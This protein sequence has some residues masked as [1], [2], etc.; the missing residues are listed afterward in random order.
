MPFKSSL[1][2]ALLL[3]ILNA[4]SLLAQT[5]ELNLDQGRVLARQA[6]LN[7]QFNVA[8]SL[9][10]ALLQA[11]P[12]D[13]AAL[14]ILAASHPQN[15]DAR[16]GRR[17]GA[18]AFRLS[19]TPDE[20]YEAARLT[21]LAA[22]NEE[23]YTL[24]QYW[25]RRAAANAPNEQALNQTRNDY[26]GLRRLNP[27]SFNINGTISP[28]NNLNGGS[29]DECLVIEGVNDSDGTPLCG[30][31]SGDAQALSGWAATANVTLNYVISR[32]ANQR[33]SLTARG[34]AR[35]VWLSDEAQD[36]SPRSRNSDFATQVLELGVRHQ[37][38]AGEGAITAEGLYGWSWFGGELSAQYARGR[39]SY[40]RNIT[41]QTELSMTAQLDAIDVQSAVAPRTNYA[42]SLSASFAHTLDGGNR[43][44]GSVGISGQSSEQPNERF[45]TARLQLGY[46]WGEQIGPAQLSVGAG[47]VWSDYRDYTVA[48]IAV[49]DG[50]QDTRAFATVSAAFPDVEYAGF[51]PVVSTSYQ[52]TTSNVSRFER[53]EFNLSLSIRSSF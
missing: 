49:P 34:Y 22:A 2:A 21:A 45:E 16:D 46:A 3:I 17:A 8:I 39:L 37:R 15:G 33:T 50:R 30:L 14:V 4:S 35:Q 40:S 41:Q 5:L 19:T 18:Q 42:R 27:L 32:S 7:G 29:D 11:N 53:D 12:N 44:T 25:L 31:L 52:D 6:A 20:R 43:V 10:D 9:A 26:R 48:F 1:T 38:R 23:R 28:T 24:S 51:I 47:V 13:R 36:L